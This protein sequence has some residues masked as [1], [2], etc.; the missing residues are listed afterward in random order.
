[1]W[2]VYVYAV[3]HSFIDLS[4]AQNK[5]KQL[6]E[7]FCLFYLILTLP[8]FVNILLLLSAS[9]KYISDMSVKERLHIRINM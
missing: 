6:W 8:Q 2:Y 1:M 3:T 9:E 4:N 5:A 7:D